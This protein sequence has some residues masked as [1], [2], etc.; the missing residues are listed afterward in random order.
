MLCILNSEYCLFVFL[1]RMSEI[2]IASKSNT[3]VQY[4]SNKC[5]EDF[6]SSSHK[7]AVKNATQYVKRRLQY[8]QL[9]VRCQKRPIYRPAKNSYK[10]QGSSIIPTI[11][12]IKTNST[13][14]LADNLKCS[15]GSRIPITPRCKRSISLVDLSPGVNN[16]EFGDLR[17]ESN[18]NSTRREEI[19]ER[20]A[21]VEMLGVVE[22]GMEYGQTKE[23]NCQL[24]EENKAAS[25]VCRVLLMNAW[26]KRR[27][28]VV[29]LQTNVEQLNQQV[30]HLHIQ[31]VVLRRLLETENGRIGK[32]T[33]EINQTKLQL[34][35]VIQEKETLILEKENLERKVQSIRDSSEQEKVA[36]ENLRNQLFGLKSQLEALDGQITRDREKILKL[37]EDK[38]ILT[39]KI[40]ANEEQLKNER[41]KNE[42]LKLLVASSDEKAQLS[43]KELKKKEEEAEKLKEQLKLSKNVAT[44]LENKLS[45]REAALRKVETAFNSQ[46]FELNELKERL[47]RQSQE[48]GWS[49]RVLQFAGSFVRAPRAILRS[50]SFFSSSGTN[51]L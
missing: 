2:T 15:S 14:N 37:R 9:P 39:E 17:S 32:I 3:E 20:K 4:L 16:P 6:T 35:E 40:T 25:L 48:I 5:H 42:E 50:L 28:E 27:E 13:K 43:F 38:K 10:L 22:I 36:A 31:I 51:I 11:N 34:N 49:T 12:L 41:L 29:Q 46:I 8:S 26:R 44:A 47:I 24:E 45:D 23:M 1:F 7:A 19:E 33:H 18:S 30:D 21:A